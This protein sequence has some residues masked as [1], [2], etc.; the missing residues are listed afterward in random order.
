MIGESGFSAMARIAAVALALAG[1]AQART[2]AERQLAEARQHLTVN[3]IPIHPRAVQDLLPIGSDAAPGPVAIDLATAV[4]GNRYHGEVLRHE[5]LG[6][7][8]ELGRATDGAS[9]GWI[10]YRSLGRLGDGRHV[11][12]VHENGGG[13]LVSVVLLLVDIVTDSTLD[14]EGRAMRRALIRNRGMIR[15]GDRYAGEVRVRTHRIE[16]GADPRSG[17]PA[18]VIDVR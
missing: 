4:H 18:R 12:L 7:L 10:A 8:V 14:N 16:I 5:N 17:T 2:P 13:T 15:L 6:W 9:P 1:A 11:L 3:G